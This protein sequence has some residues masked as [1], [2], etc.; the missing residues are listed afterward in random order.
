MADQT[1]TTSYHHHSPIAIFEQQA[2]IPDIQM[3]EQNLEEGDISIHTDKTEEDEAPLQETQP[4]D[5][6]PLSSQEQREKEE[7]ESSIWGFL[8]PCT[9]AVSRIDLFKGKERYTFGRD[10]KS[11]FVFNA[12]KISA[13]F[14]LCRVRIFFNCL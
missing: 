11:D 5:E 6:E 7:H 10:P 14:V 9:S 4:V 1:P 8:H 13:Y 2:S 12:A 3:S